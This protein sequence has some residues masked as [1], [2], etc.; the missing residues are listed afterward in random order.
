MKAANDRQKSYVDKRKRQLK[1]QEGDKVFLKVS[2]MKGVMRFGKKGKLSPRYIGPFLITKCIGEVA[3]QLELPKSMQGIHPV[4]HVSMLRKY[5]PD[6]SHVIR[7]EPLQL[8]HKL[9]YEGN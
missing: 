8:D 1:F 4:F 9:T 3:Y 6:A 5:V 7:D 2:P